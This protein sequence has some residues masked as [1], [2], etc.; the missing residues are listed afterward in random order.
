ML[1]FL[2]VAMKYLLLL[3]TFLFFSTISAISDTKDEITGAFGVIIGELFTLE[4]VDSIRER[5]PLCGMREPFNPKNPYEFFSDYY[6]HTTPRSNLVA[7]IRASGKANNLSDC[8]HEKKF[9]LTTLRD[10]YP[11]LT[12]GDD[13]LI[14]E[15][16]G[17]KISASCLEVQESTVLQLVY[18]DIQLCEQANKEEKIF[19]QEARD[20][21]GL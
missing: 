12:F 17:R 3:V 6:V 2:G 14:D 19:V 16:T 4:I 11:T 7:A 21:S 1:P 15:H 5:T 9:I 10:K 8:E 18:I 13:T 20:A